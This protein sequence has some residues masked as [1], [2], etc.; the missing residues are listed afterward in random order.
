MQQCRAR[1]AACGRA[2]A[3]RAAA[4]RSRP[5]SPR[6]PSGARR[7]ASRPTRSSWRR[8][9]PPSIATAAW[10]GPSPSRSSR[11]GSRSAWRAR[12]T[13]ARCLGLLGVSAPAGDVA[14]TGRWR[15]S[16]RW[17]GQS[18][19]RGPR[20]GARRPRGAAWE[21][22]PRRLPGR[23]PGGASGA[24]AA[25]HD[26]EREHDGDRHQIR[27]QVEAVCGGR[28]STAGPYWSTSAF[29]ICASLLPSS[30]SPWMYA[31]SRSAC[32]DW[33][34]FS[35]I[36]HVTHITW[37]SIA[38]REARGVAVGGV[39]AAPVALAPEAARTASTASAPGRCLPGRTRLGEV[40]CLTGSAQRTPRQKAGTLVGRPRARSITTG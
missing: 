37:R 29:L 14:G 16:N 40:R 18:V 8:A 19:R 32:G 28:P 4:R 22:A 34:T 26:D 35:G 36:L 5:S 9:S 1:A 15:A 6:R 11:C 33:A 12:R 7:T 13:I 2:G 24:A 27:R 17:G 30:I 20:P 39:A 25:E 23:G 3:D 31:R 38:G 10:S 21:A